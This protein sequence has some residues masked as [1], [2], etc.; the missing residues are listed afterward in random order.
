MTNF[1][2]SGLNLINTWLQPGADAYC[3]AHELFSTASG[4]SD[5]KTKAV[6]TAQRIYTALHRP[7]G[8]C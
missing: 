1:Q 7:E 5:A 3:T 4:R 6:E 2:R 8:W